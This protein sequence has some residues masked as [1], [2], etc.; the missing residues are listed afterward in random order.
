MI[1]VVFLTLNQAIK[2]FVLFPD[3]TTFGLN[4]RRGLGFD[5]LDEYPF[6][7]N[8]MHDDDFNTYI[9]GHTGYTG[10]MIWIDLLR[11]IYCI[12]LTNRVYPDE[13][14]SIVPVRKKLITYLFNFSDVSTG[15]FSCQRG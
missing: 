13:K 12:F 10:T 9:V 6:S 2:N 11:K 3:S 1:I 15:E 14:S 8:H 4:K 5:I 7:E